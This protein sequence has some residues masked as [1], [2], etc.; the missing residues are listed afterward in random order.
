VNVRSSLS[1]FPLLI[2]TDLHNR[3]VSI[4]PKLETKFWLMDYGRFAYSLCLTLVSV[5]PSIHPSILPFNKME[6][7]CVSSVAFYLYFN[8]TRFEIVGDFV[9]YHNF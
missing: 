4:G 3:N 8:G 2:C 7:V 1:K 6:H 5:H 9:D